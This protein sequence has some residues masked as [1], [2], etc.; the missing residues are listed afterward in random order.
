MELDE[1]KK[2]LH[3]KWNGH[4][5][6]EAIHKIGENLC[7]LY[8]WQ[9]TNNQNTWGD[10]KTKFE[11]KNQWPNEQM[12]KLTEKRF[13]KGKSPNGQKKKKSEETLISGHKNL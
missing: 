1:I 10:Q 2:L 6:E 13:F 12:G 7:H 9:G 5:I 8:I 11:K 4:Q 3:N